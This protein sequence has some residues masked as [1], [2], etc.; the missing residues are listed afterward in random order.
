MKSSSSKT[1]RK[2]SYDVIVIGGGAAGMMAAGRAAERGKRVLLLEKNPA[3][4]EKLKITGGGRCNITNAEEDE[5]ILLS[6]YGTAAGFLHSSFA[7][8]GMTD[9][10]SFFASRGLPLVVEASKRA[11][12]ETQKAMDVFRVLET[13]LKT[14]G[15]DVF[16]NTPVKKIEVKRGNIERVITP[17]A[18][19]SATSYILATG[20]K[21]HPKTGSTGDGFRWLR[22]LGHTVAEPTPTIV[23]ISVKDAWIKSLSGVTLSGIKIDFFVGEKKQLTLKGKVLCTHFGLS[24]PLILN[25]AWKIA[26]LLEEGPVAALIDT[27]PTLDLGA[28]DTHVTNIFDENKN[29]TLKN[30]FKHITPD[31]SAHALLPLLKE[32]DPEKKV[33]SVTKD[34][35]KMIVRFLKAIPFTVQ[36]LMGYEKAVVADGGLSIRDVDAK[37]MQSKRYDNLHVTGDILHIKRPSGGYSLQLCWTTGYVAGSHA[38]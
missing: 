21:S 15:V 35:R 7:Q 31:G 27:H 2:T 11:F 20:G 16:T 33:H 23:P 6:H 28:L 36:G 18:E 26:D 5:H 34:E 25:A 13:Y 24:G 3:L 12:P 14:G 9:T 32:L 10:C 22:D 29:K 37:T 1:S 38:G 30:I 17:T 8:F 19:F 4:G